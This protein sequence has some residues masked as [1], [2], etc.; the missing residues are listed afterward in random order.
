MNERILELLYRSFEE[1]LTAGKAKILEDA[2]AGSKELRQ[3][4][5]KI[6][7]LRQMISSSG[8]DRFRPFFVERVMGRLRSLRKGINNSWAFQEW[9]FRIFR[10]VATAGAVVAVCLVILNLVQTEGASLAAALGLSQISIGDILEF[11]VDSI[12][13]GLS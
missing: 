6:E 3:E 7:A 4:K 9:L 5:A 1:Q 10:L 11:P 8:T 2:L 12:L 13:E